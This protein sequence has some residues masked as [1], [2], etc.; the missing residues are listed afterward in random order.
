MV[1]KNV[2][3][4][5]LWMKVASALEEVRDSLENVTCIYDNFDNNFQIEN[6]QASTLTQNGTGPVGPVSPRIYWSCKNF[7]GPTNF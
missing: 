7:T 5:V 1:F 3:V 4:L 2:C 6:D